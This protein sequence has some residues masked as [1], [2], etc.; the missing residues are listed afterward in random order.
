M[1]FTYNLS[2]YLES[3]CMY[4]HVGCVHVNICIGCAF[5]N[6]SLWPLPIHTYCLINSKLATCLQVLV[7]RKVTAADSVPAQAHALSR[8]GK[9]W[10]TVYFNIF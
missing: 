10:I 6:S 1:I 9:Y 2:T 3:F 4:L 5:V 7:D 8:E